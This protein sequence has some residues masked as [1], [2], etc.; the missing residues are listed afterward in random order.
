M[1]AGSEWGVLLHLHGFFSKLGNIAAGFP[2]RCD[3]FSVLVELDAGLPF[4][5]NFLLPVV[6]TCVLILFSLRSNPDMMDIEV[7]LVSMQSSMYQIVAEHMKMIVYSLPQL[8]ADLVTYPHLFA[9]C[10]SS[11]YQYFPFALMFLHFPLVFQFQE[12]ERKSKNVFLN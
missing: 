6:V 3:P 5:P 9:C 8:V 11:C 12:T 4:V 7:P 2:P 10:L 1:F